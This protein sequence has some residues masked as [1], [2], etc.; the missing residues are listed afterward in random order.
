[1]KRIFQ[2]L[3]GILSFETL[4]LLYLFAG[5]YKREELLK[6]SFS[7][8]DL[9]PVLFVASVI[10]GVL[11]FIINKMKI[12]KQSFIMIFTFMIFICY[13]GLSLSWSKGNEYGTIKTIYLGF[14]N[15][16]N[17][18]AAAIIIAPDPKRLRR[19]MFGFVIVS[20]IYAGMALTFLLHSGSEGPIELSVTN[21]DGVSLIICTGIAVLICYIIDTSKSII[22]R[23]SSLV[24][25][26]IYFIILLFVGHRGYLISTVF[27]MG[28]VV[29][30]IP[31]TSNSFGNISINKRPIIIILL[32]LISFMV[33]LPL[34][35][36]EP[37]TMSRLALL[38]EPSQHSSSSTRLM[39]YKEA[40]HMWAQHPLF[41]SGI[42]SFPIIIGLG[43]IREY[44]HNVILEILAELGLVGLLIFGLLLFFGLRILVKNFFTNTPLTLFIFL[45]FTISFIESLF[46]SDISDHRLLILSLGL[47][48]L[49]QK[50]KSIYDES[51]ESSLILAEVSQVVLENSR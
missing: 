39:Y 46:S 50:T 8:P 23:V 26:C 27:A 14:Q 36:N 51:Q 9:T 22:N 43:D 45:L 32:L 33:I 40:F 29:F 13:T 17:L 7:P 37:I 28:A 25:C 31:N 42:G 44:P 24:L 18:I 19:L 4:F 21:Y 2:S 35:G 16:W 49:P 41:G 10:I 1:M 38:S 5:Q 34:I 3:S 15:F 11:I 48:M 12:S 20:M 6:Q 47:M 30:I